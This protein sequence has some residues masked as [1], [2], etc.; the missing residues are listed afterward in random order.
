MRRFLLQHPILRKSLWS[1][2]FLGLFVMGK[3]IPLPYTDA[4]SALIDTPLNNIILIATGGNLAQ[5]SLFTLG[6]Q[7]WMAGMIIA[8]LLGRSKRLKLSQKRLE[9]IRKTIILLLAF[10]QGAVTVAYMKLTVINPMTKLMVLI[11]L[12]AGAMMVMWLAEMNGKL[13]LGGPMI[14][15]LANVIQSSIG[16][17]L[18]ALIPLIK[19]TET[20]ILFIIGALVALVLFTL[21]NVV[22][23][24]AEYRIPLTRI[25]VD[26]KYTKKSDIPI[27]LT[28]AGGMPVMFAIGFAGIPIYLFQF[29]MVIFPKVR[30]FQWLS[31]N[32][33]LTML[34]GV[35]FY[36]IVL[37]ILAI[38]FA[39]VNVDPE[40]QAENL[41]NSGDFIPGVL[42]GRD[43]EDYIRKIVK[44]FAF[45]GAVYIVVISGVPLFWGVGNQ[46]RMMLAMIPGYI[47]MIIG[48]AMMIED[49][50]NTL[51]IKNK[52]RPLFEGER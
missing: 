34:P 43:T 41:R 50:I 1:M 51:R 5:L 18:T 35:W 10:M 36:I 32:L 23:D 28:P 38:M 6:I 21:L 22:M 29:L 33:Q 27:K 48:F 37:F 39:Y 26:S 12:I 46:Q 16:G 20:M 11:V 47:F 15:V 9:R 40:Q 8:D 44:H 49:Q 24:R 2:L 14:M 30:A 4:K 7:P 25:L 45:I 19:N 31:T 3:W 13:G 52:Y 17:V 42:P